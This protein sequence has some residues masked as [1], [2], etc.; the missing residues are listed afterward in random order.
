MNTN[1]K[2][3]LIITFVLTAFIAISNVLSFASVS[4]PKP[5]PPQ[6][7]ALG[8]QNILGWIQAIGVAVALGMLMIIGMRYVSAG[9]DEKAKIKDQ[10]ITYVFGAFCIFAAVAILQIIKTISDAL[11]K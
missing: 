2:R 3:A 4:I 9:A 7:D 5:Q 8:L 11:K 10:A 6:G 1:K